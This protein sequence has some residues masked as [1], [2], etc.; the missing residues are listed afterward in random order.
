MSCSCI[1]CRKPKMREPGPPP[2]GGGGG[3][4]LRSEL[5]TATP[6]NEIDRGLNKEKKNADKRAEQQGDDSIPKLNPPFPYRVIPP[7][8]D[9][10]RFPADPPETLAV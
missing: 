8:L 1:L 2:L 3:V 6:V 9:Y 10:L 7:P 5:P 4:P